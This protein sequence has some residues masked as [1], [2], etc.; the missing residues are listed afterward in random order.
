MTETVRIISHS[1]AETIAIGCG[2]GKLLQPGDV[3]CLAGGLGAGKTC[4]ARGIAIGLGADEARVSSPTFV[5]AQEYRGRIPMYHLDLYR[6][7]SAE[8]VEEAGLDEYVGGDGVAVIEWPDVY[9]PLLNMD[10]LTVE[11]RT[12][13]T[14]ERELVLTPQGDR[15]RSILEEMR[16]C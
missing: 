1:P 6:L 8:E 11:I 7:T 9:S 16:P 2:L 12:T 5:L 3:L 4:L 10:R 13:A 14:F 15:Y